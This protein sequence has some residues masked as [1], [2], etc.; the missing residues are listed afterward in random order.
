MLRMDQIAAGHMIVR[1]EMAADAQSVDRLLRTAFSTDAEA[2]LVARLRG[3]GDAAIALVA[4]DGGV[5][6]G[7]VL[8]SPMR[9]NI[10][11]LGLGPL[12]VAERLRGR[13]TG[14][15]LVTAGIA[16]ARMAGWQAIFVLGDPNYYRRFGFS[17]EVAR[18]FDNKYAGPHFMALPLDQ[19]NAT[20]FAGPVDYARAFDGLA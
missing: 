7:H 4:D 3:D 5:I 9:A 20:A 10:R 1:D 11:A 2:Q 6:A 8:F 16:R 19:D 17:P 13:G 14:T 18:R 12:A 15:L